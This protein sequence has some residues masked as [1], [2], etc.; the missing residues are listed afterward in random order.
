M[1]VMKFGGSSLESGTSI[2]RVT[3]IVK[4]YRDAA[5]VVVVSAM[6]KTTNQLLEIAAD[7]GMG[8]SYAAWQGLKDL[9][10]YHSDVAA[11]V[12]S[13]EV[14]ERLE[15]SIRRHFDS[16]RDIVFHVA[17]DCVE[18]TPAL[19]DEIMSFGERLSSEVVTA[20]LSCAGIPAAHLDSRQV[21][22]TND[23][24]THAVPQLWETYA[25][26]R[27][28]VPQLA[29][30]RTV[31]MGG[32][33][34][35]TESG[36]T[37]T[38]GRGGSDLTASVV[39]AGISA[40]EIQIWT[41][42]DGMLTCDPRILNGGYRLRNISYQEA[43]EMAQ[44]GA[45][46]LH[47]DTV[48][49]AIRQRIPITIRNSRRP[50]VEGTR[51]TA[52]AGECGN[53]VKSIACRPDVTVLE[54]RSRSDLPDS[55]DGAELVAKNGDAVY[56]AVK[57]SELR[58]NLRMKMDTCSEVRLHAERAVL[59]L[60]GEGIPAVP[61]LA[62]R[63]LGVLKNSEAFIV[64]DDGSRLS[65]TVMIPQ[66]LLRRCM[67]SL[68]NEFFRQV[69]PAVFAAVAR[70]EEIAHKQVEIAQEQRRPKTRPVLAL[71]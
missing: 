20:A 64:R 12:A 22:L 62:S 33:I 55:L 5:P 53:P 8:R 52:G 9:W 69:D 41:D 40:E 15:R 24:H 37:T 49:P 60:T 3:D 4:S 31:V 6:G 26:L 47:P 32:F 1:I 10:E 56:L 19:K 27:R 17:D 59:T 58:E 45:K 43:I 34:G 28:V 30:T 18:L 68:H 50:H 13:G 16:L 42:V 38:L 21:I 65:L 2:R 54:I 57:S 48:A 39:G 67:E 71:V 35:A 14:L 63:V 46:V 51:I 44:A 70:E 25:K 61:D 7:A 36:A 66:R 23:H 11:E 29:K